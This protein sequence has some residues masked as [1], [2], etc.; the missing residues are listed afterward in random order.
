MTIQETPSH[1]QAVRR[2]YENE[3]VAKEPTAPSDIIYIACH[4][5]VSLGNE[6]ILWSDVLAAF[7]DVVHVCSGTALIPFL[8]G[9]DFQKYVC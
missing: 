6:F 5:D 8:K 9:P 2:V 3:T 4:P 1:S 7:K